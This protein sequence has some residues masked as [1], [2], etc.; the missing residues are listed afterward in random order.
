[1]RKKIN[2]SSAEVSGSDSIYENNYLTIGLSTKNNSQINTN[3]VLDSV[4]TDHMTGNQM[5][6]KNYRIIISDQ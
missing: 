2:C 6:L 4:A 3:W 1:V 5:L